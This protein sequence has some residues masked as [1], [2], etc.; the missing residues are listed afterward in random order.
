MVVLGDMGRS[1]RMQYH[2]L[3][4]LK[5]GYSVEF[6]G[7]GGVLCDTVMPDRTTVKENHRTFQIYSSR[8]TY[9]KCTA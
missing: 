1:P 5:A 7:Y 2:C 3:S 8:C 6:V 9:T 4:L